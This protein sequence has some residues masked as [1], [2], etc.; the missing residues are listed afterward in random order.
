M[1]FS[2]F[3]QFNTVAI[4]NRGRIWKKQKGSS[5]SRSGQHEESHIRIQNNE[6]S[7]THLPSHTIVQFDSPRYLSSLPPSNTNTISDHNVHGS[8]RIKDSNLNQFITSYPFQAQS[9]NVV[10]QPLRIEPKICVKEGVNP[11]WLEMSGYFG[12]QGGI[13]S[14]DQSDVVLE[15]PPG[16]I[17][18]SHPWQLIIVRVS[19][20]PGIFSI[21]LEKEELFLSPLVDCESPGLHA[22]QKD[23]IIKLPHRAHLRPEWQFTVHYTDGSLS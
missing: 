8:N 19:R 6:S 4:S 11:Y 3:L 10:A 13:L 23:V 1:L 18:E 20:I 2:F 16:A 14:C 15:I 5:S 12:P 17:P 21:A 9:E 7:S 22:F